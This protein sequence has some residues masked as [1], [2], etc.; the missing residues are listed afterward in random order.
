MCQIGDQNASAACARPSAA[1]AGSPVA[2][3]SGQRMTRPP[4]ALEPSVGL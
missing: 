2:V 1:V 4:A 3:S